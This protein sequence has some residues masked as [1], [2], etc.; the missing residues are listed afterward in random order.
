[1]MRLSAPAW[2]LRNGW[3]PV[4]LAWGAALAAVGFALTYEAWADLLRIALRDEEASHALLVPVIVAWLVWVRRGRIRHCRPIGRWIGPVVAAIGVGM[5][6]LGEARLIESFWHGGAIILAIGCF[7]TVLGRQVLWDFL[8]AFLV[9]MFLIPVPG[10]IR[11]RIAI[12]LQRSTAQATQEVCAIAGMS[13]DRT[14]NLLRIN[15]VDVA[16]AE[17][18]NGMRMTFALML[19]SFAFAMTTPLRWYVRVLVVLLSPLSAVLCNVIRLVPTVWVFGN[20]TVSTAQ[21]FH[22]ISGWLMLFI[23]F[24]ALMGVIRLLRWFAVPVVPYPL[25]FD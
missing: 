4:D 3:R 22:D 1:M 12:P 7:L 21:L 16:I 17:A 23:G 8:P 25:A 13:V 19:V 24:V 10:R 15:D 18:C 5:Y 14:G 20:C 11:Q 2:F 6:L 9:L